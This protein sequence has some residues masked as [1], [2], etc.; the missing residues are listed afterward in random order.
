MDLDKIV[1]ELKSERDR[2]DRAINALV[3]GVGAVSSPRATGAGVPKRAKGISAAGR[4][5]LSEAMK[6]RWAAR[7]SKSTEASRVIASA[8]KGGAKRGMSAAA[9]KRISEAMKKR[10]TEKRKNASLGGVDRKAKLD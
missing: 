5:R 8:T 7:K 4:R 1:S 10:W 9:R 6:A 3:D 2:I